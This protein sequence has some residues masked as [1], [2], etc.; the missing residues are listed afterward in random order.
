MFFFM[1]YNTYLLRKGE[2]RKSYTMEFKRSVI[3]F[4][5]DNSNR[6]QRKNIKLIAKGFVNETRRKIV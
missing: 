5:Q 3:K 2:T 1:R 4:A 6:V